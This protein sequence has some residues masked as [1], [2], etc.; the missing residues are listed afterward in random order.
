MGPLR[1]ACLAA[2]SLATAACLSSSP[3]GVP[4]LESTDSG[5]GDGDGDGDRAQCSDLEVSCGGECTD[6][7]NDILHCGGCF[8]ECGSSQDCQVGGC[9]SVCGPG[10][11]MCDGASCA[12][13]SIDTDHCGR[14]GNTCGADA[15]CDAGV[16][17]CGSGEELCDGGCIDIFTDVNNC[18]GCGIPCEPRNAFGVCEGGGCAVVECDPGWGDCDGDPRSG[19]E[20]ST[21]GDPLNCGGC[22]IACPTPDCQ[23]GLCLGGPGGVRITNGRDAYGHHGACEGWNGCR[24]ADTCALWACQYRGFMGV[25]SWGRQDICGNFDECYLFED[26]NRLDESWGNGDGCDLMGVGDIICF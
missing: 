21:D 17:T 18:G 5:D 23:T 11:E 9:V 2:F 3:L 4:E 20:T 24:N 10:T 12:D 13:L 1:A 8:S 19:C 6:V 7:E 26:Q 16:C 14:C 22:G 15:F 25:V